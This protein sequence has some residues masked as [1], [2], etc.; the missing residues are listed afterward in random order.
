MNKQKELAKNTIIITIGKI[1]TQFMSFLLMPLYT[2]VLTKNEYGIVDLLATYTSLF[3]PIIFFQVDQAVF[4]FLIDTRNNKESTEA[5][6]TTTNVFMLIQLIVAITL[7]FG[8]QLFIDFNFKWY[9]LFSIFSAIIFNMMLQILRG[10]GDNFTY[11]IGSF[12]SAFLQILGNVI[13]LK[14]FKFDI[15][16]MLLAT[17][18][19]QLFV[20]I[21]IFIKKK[22]YNYI[23][24]KR[25][26]IDCLKT[27]LRYSFPLVPNALC[28]WALNASDRTIVML[29]LGTAANGLLSV[30]HK[31][32]SV[33]ITIF[34][35]FNISWT[36]SSSLHMQD[37]DR[38]IFFSDVIVSMFKLFMCVGLALIAIMPF[39][40]HLL[41]NKQYTEG[42]GLIP[43]FILASM[44]NVVVGLYSVV[45]VALKKTNEI[46]KTSL[47]S[48]IINIIVHLVLVKFLGLYAAPISSVVAFMSMAI[49][50]YFDIKR[51]VNIKLKTS[52]IL[53]IVIMF[54][55]E[56]IIYY[57]SNIIIQ[58]IWLMMIIMMSIYINISIIKPILK[59]FIK[60]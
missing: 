56:V 41:V 11:A 58:L 27:V 35:I 26:S 37:E 50:R 46:A 15:V 55:V 30:G 38:D 7:F 54:T 52:I 23:K 53:F 47:Y 32:S 16:G 51:Y 1:C 19:S 9:W 25:F 36:E 28:W 29:F 24:L 10:L 57:C 59:K 34:N 12:A 6:I 2:T 49:Y 14:V 18:L 22:I 21:Y 8:V 20:A 45:Y 13:F 3:V 44:F 48:G 39:V 43:V 33:Y 31:F 5:L 40:F 42:Y 60:R 17:I 4:R